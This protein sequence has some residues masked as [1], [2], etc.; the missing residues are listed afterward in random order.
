V[1]PT[2]VVPIVLLG[3]AA[4]TV[5]AIVPARTA[6]R[7]PVL[8]ALAGRRPLGR[9]P[10]WLPVTGFFVSAGGLALLGLAAF[11][12]FSATGPHPQV[13]ALTAIAG[14]VSVLLG[15]CAVAPMYVSVLEPVASR[16][17]GSWRVATRSLARQ[18]TRTSAVVCAI[19]AT[20]ALA[21]AASSLV[22]TAHH[23]ADHRAG[24]IR[25]DAVLLSTNIREGGPDRPPPATLEAA[26]AKVVR[27]VSRFRLQISDPLTTTWKFTGFALDHPA[28]GQYVQ[29]VSDGAIW[30]TPSGNSALP[31]GIADH[32]LIGAYELSNS[33]QRELTKHGILALAYARGHATLTLAIRAAP[34]SAVTRRHELDVPLVDGR[35][36]RIG[37][38]PSVLL[39]PEKAAALGVTIQKST[40]AL[41]SA[42]SLTS[43][44]R[45]SIA[46][47]GADAQDAIPP[48]TDLAV[49]YEYYLPPTGVDPLLLEWLLVGLAL[50][51]TLFVV[52]VN[53]ALSAAE[54]RDER[55]VLTVVGAAPGAMSRTNAYK[56]ALLTA[57]GSVLAIPVGTLPV[58]VF[59]AASNRANFVF[60]VRVVAL[61]VL[62]LPIAAG[63]VTIAA[64][65]LALR[66]RPVRISTM[67][68]D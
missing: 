2:D 58:V 40:L 17:R 24:S 52:A 64:S 68:F 27:P 63:A 44:Q 46:D 31:V 41:L 20:A 29:L 26:V 55:D 18:R 13:W 15:A 43:D 42:H 33:D 5:A 49:N 45:N 3:V 8:S 39:T 59:L 22:L 11:G 57:M 21:I 61:L 4:A 28:N 35:E 1:S 7:V 50:M 25:S 66:L 62:A 9:V 60:P 47:I 65:S 12:G 10:R 23:N 38:L 53:L 36:Y 32:S 67:A 56:A 19:A 14:G 6:S 30:S 54:T 51:L 37:P 16:S 34:H 48:R